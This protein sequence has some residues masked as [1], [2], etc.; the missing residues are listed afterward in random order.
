MSVENIAE[1]WETQL[2]SIIDSYFKNTDN[3]LC[4]NQLDSYNRFL[5]INIPKTI[6][7][8]NPLILS[9]KPIKDEKD[10]LTSEFLFE[11]RVTVGGSIK[12]VIPSDENTSYNP[13]KV[14]LID[15][16]LNDKNEL[17]H[18]YSTIND[19]I[20]INDATSIYI[21]K[22]VIQEITRI[23]KETIV[24]QKP[25]YPNEARLK[26]ITYRT[27][28]QTDVII[29]YIVNDKKQPRVIRRFKNIS[30][31]HIPIM[32]Q[33]KICSLYG[34]KY[35]TLTL[36][37]ECQYDH[38]GYFIIDG[39]EKVIIAQERQIENKIYVSQIKDENEK[40][41]VEAE[42]RSTPENK[43]Q[44][45]R[46]TS[47]YVSRRTIDEKPI[48]LLVNEKKKKIKPSPY[49]IKDGIYV[50]IPQLKEKIPLFIVFRALGITTDEDILKMIIGNI[51]TTLGQRFCDFLI[52]SIKNTDIYLTNIW[53]TYGFRS[54]INVNGKQVLMN[55][56]RH[57]IMTKDEALL[58]MSYLIDEKF[59]NKSITNLNI[60]LAFMDIILKDHFLPHVGQYDIHKA[61]YLGHMTYELLETIHGLKPFTDRDN[62][63]YKR[64]DLAGYMISSL[65]RDLYFRVK[66]RLVEVCNINFSKNDTNNFW[67]EKD[68]DNVFW[69]NLP[70]EYTDSNFTKYRLY[71]LVGG[72]TP[73][74]TNSIISINKII[75]QDIMDDG[76]IFAFK[77]AWGLKN[78]PGNKEGVVQDLAR[79]SYVG[80]VSHLRRVNTPLSASAKVRAPHALHPSSWGIMCPSETPDGGNIGLRKNLSIFAIISAGTNS[81]RLMRCLYNL[82]MESISQVDKDMYKYT[83]IYLN[84]RIVGYTRNPLDFYNTMKLLKRNAIINVY[85]SVTFNN[86]K[87]IIKIN[88]DSGRGIRPVLTVNSNNELNIFK[89]IPTT[90]K[91]VIQS[92]IDG[93]INWNH[94]IGGFRNIEL[95]KPFDDQDE[96]YYMDEH[97]AYKNEELE[98]LSGVIE[99]IDKDEE[100][101][102]LIALTIRDLS[103]KEY[104]YNFC[105]IHPSL[106]LGLLANCIPFIEMNPGPRHLYAVGQSKQALGLYASNYR[107]RM[108]TKG[109]IMYYPQKSIVKNR[110]ERYLFTNELP[111]GI[112][113]IVAIG[114]FT[115]YN[116]EDS[117]IFNKASV[118]RGLFRTVKY[119]TY[120]AKDEME[121]MKITEKIMKPDPKYTTGLKS[122]NYTKLD[123][124][125]IILE[126][127]KINEN[128]ILIGKCVL[129]DKDVTGNQ[130]YIDNSDFVKRNEDGF[131]D[132]VYSN[133]GNDEQRYVK[134]RIRKDKKPELGDKFCSRYGQKGT[135]GMLMD[136]YNMPFSR[137]GIQPD[138]IVNAHAFPSR[139]TIAQFL[140]LVMGKA[141]VEK[142][143]FSEVAAFSEVN[144][145]NVSDALLKLGFEGY[146]NEALYCGITGEIMHVNYFI[147][148]TY[149]QRLTHQV[150]DKYQSRDDGLKTALT[151]Q[152]VGGRSLGGGGRIGEMERDAL[153]SHGAMEFL[154]ES[155][156]TRSDKD[157]IH[158][159]QSS[160]VISVYNK[161]KGL[162]R[163]FIHDETEQWFDN[164]TQ[165][166]LKNTTDPTMYIPKF[167]KLEVPYAFKLFLQ[168][169]EAMGVTMKFETETKYIKW[170]ND[171]K[172][173]SDIQLFNMI[174]IEFTQFKTDLIKNPLYWKYIED[175]IKKCL[176]PTKRSFLNDILTD[177]QTRSYL[178]ISYHK[179]L[180]SNEYV[181]TVFEEYNKNRAKQRAQDIRLLLPSDYQISSFIDI[182]CSDGSIT[183]AIAENW[184]IP[185]E[186]AFGLDVEENAY[187]TD[188][189]R[190][191]I[192]LIRY[193]SRNNTGLP[194]E[195]V[196]L[197]T[198]NEVLHH[199][200]QFDRE[201]I[202]KEIYRILKPG[203]FVFFREHD[204]NNNKEQEFYQFLQ[205]VH[206]TYIMVKD[207]NYSDYFADYFNYEYLNRHLRK[208]NFKLYKTTHI[209]TKNDPKNIQRVYTACFQKVQSDITQDITQNEP[210]S[211]LV[212]KIKDYY[213][214]TYDIATDNIVISQIKNPSQSYETAIKDRGMLYVY[215]YKWHQE[216]D[217]DIKNLKTI[218]KHL[219]VDNDQSKNISYLMS[220]FPIKELHIDARLFKLVPSSYKSSSDHNTALQMTND[221]INDITQYAGYKREDINKFNITDGTANIGGNMFPF[222]LYFKTVYGIEYDEITSKALR[223][224]MELLLYKCHDMLNHPIYGKIISK[225]INV[226]N[227]DFTKIY[228]YYD[229]QVIFL[230]VPWKGGDRYT[231]YPRV[232]YTLGDILLK[233][234][235]RMIFE[236]NKNTFCI[237][238]KLPKDYDDN[239]YSNNPLWSMYI[240]TY[241][242]YKM[243]VLLRKAVIKGGDID[244]SDGAGLFEQIKTLEDT[245]DAFT[246]NPIDE[247][248]GDIS[249]EDEKF[250]NIVKTTITPNIDQMIFNIEKETPIIQSKNAINKV[251]TNVKRIEINNEL[252]KK[253]NPDYNKSV[254]NINIEI[255]ENKPKMEY[256]DEIDEGDKLLN[257]YK[258]SDDEDILED[259][260]VD[261]DFEIM[262]RKED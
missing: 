169:V 39:K 173:R 67:I 226:R 141:C 147:G 77:M 151:H 85:T 258:K 195:S 178:A 200:S 52:P 227:G 101:K 97:F 98:M 190:D 9:Y 56:D 235:V 104:P 111:N 143:L 114:C 118:E 214:I 62:Y 55:Y 212:K 87:N 129:S 149:Y 162:Y 211:I 138:M 158:I 181:T 31:G 72:N 175:L 71:R 179:H 69:S 208:A 76:F 225:S 29:E 186:K 60:R 209:N 182:G 73:N 172:C 88:T 103:F 257:D 5:E 32:L 192:E 17:I 224:N 163:D 248:F 199:I 193:A 109:Q 136:P 161:D 252:W 261:D 125:G 140:E 205:L 135:I 43:F 54:E 8:F 14:L 131:V 57:M 25:L 45:A 26:N 64:V 128:D 168:E 153:L 130:T 174:N 100:D 28:I 237:A 90:G 198:L 15:E 146:G 95:N 83:K 132:K 159:S 218:K 110:L 231:E 92:I 245:Q 164:T 50:E 82:G 48:I 80:F 144:V 216:R 183:K 122:G 188:D 133:L 41:I 30:L 217:I 197:V 220:F 194:D 115:G 106:I 99:Y 201:Y 246:S 223:N 229:T 167:A 232:D 63:M 139:M 105:E 89:I 124:N 120:S 119:R 242:K 7:Q 94:L 24:N 20:I 176:Q 33:S 96:T 213:N 59:L 123:E 68:I 93:N 256:N 11:L 240:H 23:G 12:S 222:M 189:V 243:Y 255:N 84:E 166:T 247:K 66:N 13:E 75:N 203:G 180:F 241:N 228:N 19:P 160:G 38:G 2:W 49:F 187:I 249:E 21:A 78:A 165:Q 117:I 196:D 236:T 253:N 202:L 262:S 44:P 251:D 145:E 177:I 86:M 6:R 112:N 127:V 107:N 3:Y 34:M 74:D 234:L 184:N 221:I 102:S 42:V 210:T 219:D 1:K 259:V 254:K 121:G 207:E 156:M 260:S 36:M 35:D 108:D 126:G 81:M 171:I 91:S 154:Q 18:S 79:L 65:F 22:P 61:T 47:L 40:F 152:P 157:A 239:E 206:A 27:E 46:I 113:A 244:D 70:P 4:K 142:G 16:T 170:R 58:F 185:K 230:D 116:Q 134:V 53:K 150:S 10:Q 37:G 250:D 191:R 233:E 137:R 204:V 155:F 148:P 215:S 51:D 238:L